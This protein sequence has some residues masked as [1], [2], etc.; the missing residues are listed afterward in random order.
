MDE[1]KQQIEVRHI[2]GKLLDGT[3]NRLYARF[4]LEMR[5]VVGRI[6]PLLTEGRYQS[7]QVD[8]NLQIQVFSNEKGNFV[9]LNEISGGTYQQ[10]MLSIRLALSQALISSS[11]GG[12]QFIILDEPFAFFDEHRTRKSLE[13]LPRMSEEIPQVWIISPRFDTTIGFDMHLRCTPD[14][15]TLIASGS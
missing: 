13:A 2:A 11:I 9:G 6:M 8:K 14:S 5:Y 4:N 15:D 3:H 10:L 1:Q 12:A 7:L